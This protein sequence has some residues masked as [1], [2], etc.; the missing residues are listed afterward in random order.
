MAGDTYGLIVHGHDLRREPRAA[1]GCVVDGCPPGLALDGSRHPTRSRPAPAGP[2]APRHAAPRARSSEDP[3]GRVRG[4]ARPAPRSA[5]SSRTS[6]SAAATTRRSRTASG[7]GTPTTRIN[8]STAF[9]T[10]AAAAARP[11]ARPS[12]ASRRARS[13]ASIS[14]EQ[15]GLEIRGYLAE[16]GPFKLR[17]IDLEHVDD[18][19]FFCADPDEAAAARG[20][21]R[22]AARGRRLDRR[23][24]QRH[25]VAR[26]RGARRA[27]VRQ[28]RRRDSRTGS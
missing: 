19:P 2:L 20:V 14:R 24:H 6:I 17:A 3:V 11:R 1:M 9:A 10:T 23:A 5:C 4:A 15:L 28:A 21:S 12:C 22:R 13:R 25:R 7:P 18:N 8:R 16:I 26:A 27:R